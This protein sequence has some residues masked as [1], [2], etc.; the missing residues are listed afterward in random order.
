MGWILYIWR[1]MKHQSF[2]HTQQKFK[3]METRFVAAGKL[4]SP[5]KRSEQ[6]RVSR[7][8]N[9]HQKNGRSNML[10]AIA[11]VNGGV[12]Q[13]E[14][15]GN[16][17]VRMKILVKKQDLEQMLE[18]IMEGSSK[19]YKVVNATNNQTSSTQP[20][21]SVEQ[22]LNLLRKKHLFT[23]ANKAKQQIKNRCCSS[24]RPALHS[25]PEEL[26]QQLID[27]NIIF[28]PFIIYLFFQNFRL[29]LQHMIFFWVNPVGFICYHFFWGEITIILLF[30]SFKNKVNALSIPFVN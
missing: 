16:G 3:T 30:L 8:R 11:R 29:L 5:P 13:R 2:L 12:S 28:I 22:R 14:E 23:K 18:A 4:M 1:L 25:I 20:L 21:M 9:T 7:A 19:N 15:D 24:W 17:V 6:C 27:F 26:V 10:E